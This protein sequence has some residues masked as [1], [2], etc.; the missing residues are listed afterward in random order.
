MSFWVDVR[1]CKNNMIGTFVSWPQK[2]SRNIGSASE[3]Q[4]TR[5][6][7]PM[8]SPDTARYSIIK[9]FCI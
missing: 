7:G 5:T 4:N 6:N 1:I 8:D 9:R 2:R 3:E